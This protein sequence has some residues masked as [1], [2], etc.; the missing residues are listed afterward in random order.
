MK[1]FQSFYGTQAWKACR[2][3]YRKQARGLCELCLKEGR[4]TAGEI[5]HH[6]TPLTAETVNNPDIALNFDNLMLVCRDHHAQLHDAKERR[7]KIDELGHVII[8]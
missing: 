7:F 5:V 8:L 2:D 4:F 3:A 1:D 6:K